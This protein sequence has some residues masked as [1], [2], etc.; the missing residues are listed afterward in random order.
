MW[1]VF[2]KGG[3]TSGAGA[4]DRSEGASGDCGQGAIRQ[5][6][7]RPGLMGWLET[8]TNIELYGV[9]A[10]QP[11]LGEG[12]MRVG[13]EKASGDKQWTWRGWRHR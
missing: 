6:S 8:P 4:G 9:K 12:P 2:E 13:H 5:G 11:H 7:G 10:A 1:R 3:R